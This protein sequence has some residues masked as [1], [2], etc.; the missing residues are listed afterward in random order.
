MIILDTTTKSLQ[1][2]LAGAVTTSQLPWSATYVDVNTST[3][4]GSAASASDGVTNGGTA[5]TMV[6]APGASTSRTIKAFQ[7]QNK[8]T[9]S[10]TVTII[11]NDNSTLRNIFVA[12]LAVGDNLIYEDG[13]GFQVI[14]KNGNLKTNAGGGTVTSVGLTA[15]G[16]FLTASGSPITTNG[17]ITLSD[18]TH[19]ANSLIG[20]PTGSITTPTDITLGSTLTFSAGALQTLA[21]TG[22]V[23][24]SAN[25]FVTAIGANKVTRGML[26]QG[27]G[28]SVIGVTGSST[29]NDADITGTANQVLRINSAGTSLAFGAINLASSAAVTGNLAVTNLNSGTSASSSTFWRGDGTWATPSGGSPG[30]SNTQLQFNDSSSFGGSSGLVWDKTNSRFGL[31]TISSPA[32]PF[33]A[34]Y[35]TTSGQG[36]RFAITQSQPNATDTSDIAMELDFTISANSATNELVSRVFRQAVTNSLTGGGVWTSMRCYVLQVST[37]ASTTTTNADWLY[38]T[39]GGATSGTVT[40]AVGVHIAALQGTTQWGYFDGGTTNMSVGASAIFGAAS[41]GTLPSAR[42]HAQEQTLGNEVTGSESV[43]TNTYPSDRLFQGRG[44]TT[45]NTLTTIMT[46]AMPY[47]DAAYNLEVWVI[48]R[49][50]G[51]SSGSTGDW[52]FANFRLGAASISSTLSPSGVGFPSP[53]D[54][55]SNIMINPPTAQLNATSNSLQV[56]FTGQTN[57]NFTIHAHVNIRPVVT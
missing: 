9:A 20:N 48:A 17:T 27:S 4:A 26:A 35:S 46:L 13:Q 34:A 55:G 37:S 22:D 12:I 56:Q 41:I 49:R 45:N 39:N 42:V 8:D 23:T 31:G 33:D 15:D 18:A 10:A 51:G 57:V 40:S 19:A 52:Y 38:I 43:A 44:T 24:A 16:F 7:V 5:V 32:I 29:A 47:A 6:A 3:F 25:S 28:L 2:V 1:I 11:Y 53:S 21:I 54:S 36:A 14:D 50:T 30:G